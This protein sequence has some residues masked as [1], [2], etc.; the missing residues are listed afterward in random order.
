LDAAK[1][2]CIH[3][4]CLTEDSSVG[5]RRGRS[6]PES[7]PPGSDRQHLTFPVKDGDLRTAILH[8]RLTIT[9][10]D[11]RLDAIEAALSMIM[12]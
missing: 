5:Q 9:S 6:L 2:S 8:C 12:G 7:H 3:Q 1:I 4:S 10:N 11:G